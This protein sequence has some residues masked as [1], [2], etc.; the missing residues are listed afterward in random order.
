MEDCALEHGINFQ[1]LNS[2]AVEDDGAMGMDLLRASVERSQK[3]NVTKSCTV[4]LDGKVRCIRDGGK[5]TDCEEGHTAG[6]LVEDVNALW[7]A[8][9]HRGNGSTT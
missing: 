1:R 2:C 3:A 8:S 5:W 7:H 6:D 4:R 9:M